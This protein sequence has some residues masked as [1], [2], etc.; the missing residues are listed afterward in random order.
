M[1]S[2]A[3]PTARTGLG[4]LEVLSPQA[5]LARF[6]ASAF[7]RE[8]APGYPLRQRYIQLN[9][10]LCADVVSQDVTMTEHECVPSRT[11]RRH[12]LILIFRRRSG[13]SCERKVNRSVRIPD[14]FSQHGVKLLS[15]E[16]HRPLRCRL[17]RRHDPLRRTGA[18]DKERGP[19]LRHR[20]DLRLCRRR[21]MAALQAHAQQFGAHR[22]TAMT[23]TS[24]DFRGAMTVGP[25]LFEQCYVFSIPTHGRT[26]LQL[27]TTR[28]WRAR[29]H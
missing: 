21:P 7:S 1:A 4:Y 22:V 2:A 23:Q 20:H 17:A 3:N 11:V 13:F 9:I 29:S 8:C 27:P 26:I 10:S 19:S 24:S 5:P 18:G 6:S 16:F 15:G 28:Q 12:N 25:K 14:R